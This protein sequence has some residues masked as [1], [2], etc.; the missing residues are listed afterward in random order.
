VYCIFFPHKAIFKITTADLDRLT[1]KFDDTVKEID[2]VMNMDD[3]VVASLE[4]VFQNNVKQ[5]N[6]YLSEI[7]GFKQQLSELENIRNALTCRNA[8]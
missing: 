8:H 1:K 5:L 6:V 4:Q 3:Q 7:S 2:Q